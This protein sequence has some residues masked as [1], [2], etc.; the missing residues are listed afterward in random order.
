MTDFQRVNIGKRHPAVCKALIALSSQTAVRPRSC[1][2]HARCPGHRRM[3]SVRI[4][5]FR[6]TSMTRPTHL[7]RPAA[8]PSV[9]SG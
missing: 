6:V 5:P 4:A 1:A 7:V 2:T 3:A 9:P 8:P